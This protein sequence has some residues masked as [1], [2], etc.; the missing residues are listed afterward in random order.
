MLA[1]ILII[2]VSAVLL[3]YWFRYTCVLL[4]A[5]RSGLNDEL[6]RANGLTFH[7][8]EPRLRQGG[9]VVLAH[10]ASML[11]R[12]YRVLTYLL[13]HAPGLNTSSLEQKLL[14]LDYRAMRVWYWVTRTAA[15]AQA[16][17]ALAEMAQVL[18]FLAV[19]MGE[20]AETQ[21]RA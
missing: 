13:D 15:P 8:V 9:D 12:D 14:V 20:R 5:N 21:G 4:L 1:S 3:V 6:V 18:G 10:V 17:R 7:E 16:R 19:E 11:E 2:G